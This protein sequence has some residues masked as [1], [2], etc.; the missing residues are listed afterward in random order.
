MTQ[1]REVKK[2]WEANQYFYEQKK[3]DMEQ[4]MYMKDSDYKSAFKKAFKAK[5]HADN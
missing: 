5:A 4:D 2:L 3:S 1:V